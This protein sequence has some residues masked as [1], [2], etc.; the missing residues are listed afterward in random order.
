MA[1]GSERDSRKAPDAAAAATGR[2]TPITDMVKNNLLIFESPRSLGRSSALRRH[3]GSGSGHPDFPSSVVENKFDT[4][5][6][7][8]FG[9]GQYQLVCQFRLIFGQFWE[10]TF[11]N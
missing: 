8:N 10:K 7:A 2:L 9:N 11:F 1:A 3:V 4:S 5:K 6:E